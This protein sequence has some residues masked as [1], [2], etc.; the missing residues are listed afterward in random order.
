MLGSPR[1]R[2]VR[3]RHPVGEA[4]QRFLARAKLS[5]R[6]MQVLKLV[7]EGKTNKEIADL[8]S[9]SPNTI[10]L[11]VS[12]ILRRLELKSRTQAALLSSRV[13]KWAE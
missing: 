5:K 11:H 4:G 3:Y 8:L 12:A 6:Q 9:R 2:S 10:K 1:Q 7:G 13:E